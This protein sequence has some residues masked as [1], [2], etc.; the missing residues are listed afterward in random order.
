MNPID[1]YNPAAA[2]TARPAAASAKPQGGF[3]ELMRVS[4]DRAAGAAGTRSEQLRS[5]A[6]QLVSVAFIKPLMAQMHESPFKS[7]LFH[8]G[9]GEAMFQ[10]H[11]DTVLAD[12]I[13]ERAN[14]PIAEAIYQRIARH[15]PLLQRAH[16]N[17][18]NGGLDQHG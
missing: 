6:N 15:D 1:A 9:Q 4:F 18:R 14:L 8:G 13:T 3:G 12:R 10:E 7:E 16:G 17:L 2:L 5:A 11:L